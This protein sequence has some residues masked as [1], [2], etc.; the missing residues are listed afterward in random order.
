M[1]FVTGKGKAWRATA[2]LHHEQV[3]LFVPASIA[4]WCTQ[5]AYAIESWDCVPCLLLRGGPR[6]ALGGTVACTAVSWHLAADIK[7]VIVPCVVTKT[8]YFT[9]WRS[10]LGLKRTHATVLPPKFLE[11]WNK[12]CVAQELLGAQSGP[13][14]SLPG[15][16]K[17]ADVHE[18]AACGLCYTRCDMLESQAL[19][20]K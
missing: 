7:F 9:Y 14:A 1:R 11:L 12:M 8:A 5:A 10:G 2:A 16:F 17:W 15:G 20:R 13:L 3:S 18:D 4:S 19:H 6:R